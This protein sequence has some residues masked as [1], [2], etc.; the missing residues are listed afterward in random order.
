MG[1]AGRWCQGLAVSALLLSVGLSAPQEIK[2]PDIVLALDNS[3]SMRK[4]DPQSL[5]PASVLDLARALSRGSRLGIVVFGTR[6]VVALQ[7]TPTDAPDFLSRVQ[8]SLALINYRGQQTDIPGAIERS[9]Y[10][11]REN[12]RANASRSVVLFTDGIVDAGSA[13]RDQ[14]RTAWLRKELV[15]EAH[16]LSVRIIGVAFTETADFELMQALAQSTGGLHFRI[17][18]ARQISNTFMR[19]AAILTAPPPHPVAVVPEAARFG[20]WPVPQR[21]FG[22]SFGGAIVFGTLSTLLLLA[23]MA[24]LVRR[25][26]ATIPIEATLT[27]MSDPSVVYRLKRKLSYVGRDTGCDIVI[28]HPTVGQRHVAIRFEENAF[29]L[30]DLRSTNGTWLNGVRLAAGASAREE[31]LRSGDLVRL[32][33][34]SFLFATAGGAQTEIAER[35]TQV[36]SIFC[37]NHPGKPALEYC[38][39]CGKMYCNQCVQAAG[40]QFLCTTCRT[41]EA[42]AHPM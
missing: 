27:D 17:L 37:L 34:Y 6:P 16:D 14:Q 30:R 15:Q 4:N 8:E 9:L 21:I 10:E 12:G 23:G 2:Q 35:T 36:V 32:H 22:S 42:Q 26:R 25:W 28:S 11:L 29:W 3:A 31:P 33:K 38:D 1:C 7:L 19:I 5:M 18:E 41:G 13:V 40:D 39:Q 24:W 20:H